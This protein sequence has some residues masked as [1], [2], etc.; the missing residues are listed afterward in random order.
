MK[1]ETVAKSETKTVSGNGSVPSSSE[2][3]RLLAQD[4]N[5]L[6]QIIVLLPNV[7]EVWFRREGFKNHG[8]GENTRE[9]EREQLSTLLD[10]IH[11]LDG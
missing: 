6:K 4:L 5:I 10:I 9:R 2:P 8:A 3:C 11:R 7:C 1:V